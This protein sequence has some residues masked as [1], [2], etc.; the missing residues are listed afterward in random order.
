MNSYFFNFFI[1]FVLCVLTTKFYLYLTVKFSIGQ[2]VRRDGPISHL[3]KEGTPTSGGIAIMS[4]VVLTQLLINS[5][6][7]F[8]RKFLIFLVVPVLCGAIGLADDYLKIISNSTKGFLA[9]YRIILQI[10]IAIF[11][12]LYVFKYFDLKTN[13][14]IPF[15]NKIDL[16]YLF[17]PYCVFVFLGCLNGVNLTD[18]LDGLVCSV[19]I[20]PLILFSYLTYRNNEFL[21]CG[22]SLSLI[23]ATIAFLWFNGYPAKLFM[24]DSGSLYF[25]AFL[26]TISLISGYSILLLVSGGIFIAETVSVIIQVFS[27]KMFK[28][29]V[30]K[31]APLHHHFELSGLKEPNIVLKFG[32][33]SL[34]LSLVSFLFV[35]K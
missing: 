22:A 2:K 28:K 8:F 5:H 4:S 1:A 23:G 15:N 10:I 6:L 9:R 21:I 14:I 25:G 24:G 3:K 32:I 31:M 12:S 34:L 11:T 16:S 13:I 18:G 35:Y 30:F 27:F 20:S 19:I 17:F 29:R 7:F 33:I 26:G